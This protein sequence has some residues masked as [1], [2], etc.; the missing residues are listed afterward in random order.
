TGQKKVINGYDTHEVIMTVTVHE[1]GKT[2]DQS[3]G[4]IMTTDAWMGP[5]IVAMKEI[6]DFD[7]RYYE[8]LNGPMVAGASAEQMAAAMAM[9]PSMKDAMT[10]AAAEGGKMDGTAIL[11]TTT[12]DSVKSPEQMAE[13]QKKDDDDTKSSA[14]GGIGGMMGAFGKKIAKKKTEGEP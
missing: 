6:A 11:Q 2:I 3:G 8:K 9:Y 4:L 14:S 1:K 12:M 10:K 7:R 13:D 5:K